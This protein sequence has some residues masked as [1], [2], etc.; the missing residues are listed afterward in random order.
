MAD[1][2]LAHGA[3]R[4]R[5]LF[6]DL[7]LVDTQL[8][9]ARAIVAGDQV[10]ILELVPALAAG[11]FETDGEGRQIVHPYFAQQAD[12]QAGIDAAGEQHAD[13]HRRPLA[14]G[15]GVAGGVEHACG[16]VFRV[17]CCSSGRGP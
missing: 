13:V 2:R 10:R 11:I 16:P 14:D 7:A 15:Y 5:Q 4:R 8:M 9:V 6:E 1:H 3:E 17:R 12:Q